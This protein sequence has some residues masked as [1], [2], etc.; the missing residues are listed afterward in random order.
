[1]NLFVFRNGML[2]FQWNQGES[3]QLSD[4]GNHVRRN[5]PLN[6]RAALD[7]SS[8]TTSV[9]QNPDVLS[10]TLTSNVDLVVPERFGSHSLIAHSASRRSAQ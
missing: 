8:S 2:L 6:S 1:M 9:S 3:K 5:I 10:A 4:H 7:V